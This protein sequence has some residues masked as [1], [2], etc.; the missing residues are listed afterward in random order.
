[1]DED[2]GEVGEIGSAAPVSPT[3]LRLDDLEVSEPLPSLPLPLADT[4]R[5]PAI[6]PS[7][8]ID[9]LYFTC[10]ICD[11]SKLAGLPPLRSPG[12]TWHS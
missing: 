4:L 3:S 11:I 10:E 8:L 2:D 7:A 9:A 5:R 1:M 6:T 12:I